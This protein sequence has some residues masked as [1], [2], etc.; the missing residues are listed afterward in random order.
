MVWGTC[1]GP[2]WISFQ[3]LNSPAEQLWSANCRAQSSFHSNLCEWEFAL[4][5]FLWT[6]CQP[7]KAH[8]IL[9]DAGLCVNGEF[10][11]FCFFLVFLGVYENVYMCLF[12]CVR[13]CCLRMYA[14]YGSSGAVLHLILK[15]W[16]LS[17]PKIIGQ[18]RIGSQ[19]APDFLLT[20]PSQTLG[21]RTGTWPF[22]CSE[23][24]TLVHMLGW[25]TL[26]WLVM[27]LGTYNHSFGVIPWVL[28]HGHQPV[29]QVSPAGR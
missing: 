9:A 14:E 23:D 6:E 18:A 27:S 26:Y 5:G 25:H 19:Q 2:L 22:S 10:F 24:R 11:Y 3:A 15:A 12:M 17:V 20:P 8:L 7:R 4:P 21:L 1:T 16:S 28:R 13:E 29:K